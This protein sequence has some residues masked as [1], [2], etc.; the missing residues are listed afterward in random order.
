MDAKKKTKSA[1]ESAVAATKEE[2]RR[3]IKTFRVDDCSL[4]LWARERTVRGKPVVFY[5]A[6]LE[7]SYKDASGA[8]KY[9]KSFDSDSLGK[10]TALCQQASEFLQSSQQAA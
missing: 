5:S 3:P 2:S 1:P 7:R 8:W 6:T 4:S 9:T 10:V